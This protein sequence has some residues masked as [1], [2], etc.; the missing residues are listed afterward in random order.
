MLHRWSN[1]LLLLAVVVTVSRPQSCLAQTSSP[2]L[3]LASYIA[4]LQT[5]NANV[6]KKITTPPQYDSLLK[7]TN[8]TA[9][10]PI[11]ERLG[12]IVSTK[13]TAAV[14]LSNFTSYKAEVTH[15]EG[16]SLWQFRLD[17]TGKLIARAF[18]LQTRIVTAGIS[19]SA[20]QIFGG[21]NSIFH[22]TGE[23]F[24]R[25]SP[26]WSPV[27]VGS[28]IRPS[29]SRNPAR[30]QEE[31]RIPIGSTTG[32]KG[33]PGPVVVQNP[34]MRLPLLCGA[35]GAV[36]D[37]RIV[38]F[39]FATDRQPDAASKTVS[40]VGDRQDQ[41]AFGAASVRVPEDHKYG[42]LELPSTWHL[43][44]Y[45]IYREQQDDKSHFSIKQLSFLSEADLKELVAEQGAKSAL[46]FVH[47]FNTSFEE[48]IFRNAQIVWD[49]QFHGLSVLFSWSTK[50][51]DNI[52]DYG[53]DQ[54]S[55]LSG[56]AR[57]IELLSKLQNEFGIEHINVIAH[58]M[59]NFL[60]LDA[61]QNY[62]S[63]L[64]PIHIDQLIMAAPD[65][66]RKAFSDAIPRIKPMTV[67]MT[68]YAS[69]ADKAL[70]V[71]AALAKSPRAGD[72][73]PEG[74]VI[75]ANLDTI[76]V[77]NVGDEIF[78]LN[79]SV[80]ATNREIINDMRL[81]IENGM[82]P[83]RLGDVRRAPDPPAAPTYWKYQK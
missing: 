46:I 60:V 63:S 12:S 79:H 24:G 17:D 75:L 51:G 73:P 42:R 69:S 2:E 58:S 70:R 26:T 34:C 74:P 57:F 55:A 23:I 9:G 41:L 66:D 40:F 80:F 71:S 65:I 67:G 78:G 4:A 61:L 38:E 1:L 77:T 45:E 5:S 6:L 28:T 21:N 37:S 7:E 54:V 13:I 48:A 22:T 33:S 49:L 14:S 25:A 27:I 20:G 72:V 44:G 56:R 59:G 29:E 10:Y 76:D 50:G 15:V 64:P 31:G 83:P 35:S 8:G 36:E 82:K 16:T 18:L 30:R 52:S 53:Y 68:L 19:K 3:A 81:L 39:I 62:G 47:G 32:T 43:F 11:L